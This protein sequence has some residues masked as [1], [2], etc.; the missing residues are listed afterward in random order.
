MSEK[1]RRCIHCFKMG[2]YY[3]C[4]IFLANIEDLDSENC[5]FFKEVESD[6]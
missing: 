5:E 3:M 2:N 1:C 4:R 6:V